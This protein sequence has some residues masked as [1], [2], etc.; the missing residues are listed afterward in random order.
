MVYGADG[1]TRRAQ[2]RDLLALAAAEH[3]GLSPLPE[4]HRAAHGKPCFP[5]EMGRHFNLSHSGPLALCVLDD[6]PAGADIQVVKRWRPTLPAKV[7]AP[8]E[9]DWIAAQEDRWAAFT[10]LWALKESRA[11]YTGLGLTVPIRTISVPLL[12]PGET[13]CRW[14]ELWFRLYAGPDWRAAVCGLSAPPP[15][16]LWRSLPPPKGDDPIEP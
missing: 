4:L 5:R 3:W 1:L 13:L 10:A 2:A 12:P 9:L 14:E 6:A 11:K 8:A 15:A 7:C 16:I